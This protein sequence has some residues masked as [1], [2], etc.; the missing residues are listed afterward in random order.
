LFS[1]VLD[2]ALVTRGTRLLEVGCGAGLAALLAAQRG[3]QV[4]AVDASE[5]MLAVA[6]ER[7]PQADIRQADLESLPFPDNGFDAVTAI[8]SVFYA[9][10]MAAAARELARVAAPG[11]RVVVTAWG[12]PAACEYT[13]VIDRLKPLLPPPP[14]GAPPPAPLWEIGGLDQVLTGAGLKPLERGAVVCTFV[15]ANLDLAWQA[16]RCAGVIQRAIETSG[17]EAVRSVFAETDAAHTKPDGS[18]RYRNQFVWAVGRKQGGQYAE[19]SRQQE[20]AEP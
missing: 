14:P 5:N 16:Q 10:D 11:G 12:D 13:A 9:A 4:A 18:V 1:A 17:E 6:R 8:N 2:A 19:G 7:L 3:A 15:Y 20:E